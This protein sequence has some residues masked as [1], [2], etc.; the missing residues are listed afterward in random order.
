MHP[1]V[2]PSSAFPTTVF[3]PGQADAA[4]AERVASLF[5]WMRSH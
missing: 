2:L 3:H 5:P 1:T 4:I